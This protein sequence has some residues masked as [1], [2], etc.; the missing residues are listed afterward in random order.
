MALKP[1]SVL[2]IGVGF[3]KY[4]LLC[5]E[6]LE[7]WDGRER[8][9][10]WKRRIDG[11]EAYREYILPH[12]R[13]IYDN[14]MIGDARTLLKE[15]T[16]RYDLILLIDIIEHFTP[17][18]GLE[19]LQLCEE[20]GRNLIVSTPHHALPQKA[21]FQN[22]YEVHRSEW[23]QDDFADY[24]NTTLIPDGRSLIYLIRF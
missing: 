10:D 7:L 6:Y 1:K 19:V 20:R 21:A 12:H 11:I 9:D 4:G 16:E 3:G 24:K 17:S 13:Y 5:R 8:Y 23:S 18:E 2:D 22:E 15:M 14:I